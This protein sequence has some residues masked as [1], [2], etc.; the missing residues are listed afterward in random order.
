MTINL[1]HSFI[2]FQNLQIADGDPTAPPYD[3]LLV[4]DH[5]GG[6]SDAHSLSSINSSDDDQ[7]FQSLAQWGPRFGRLADMYSGGVEEDDDTET[8]PGKTEWV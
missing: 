4:F 3:S 5:E 1:I 2:H 8:L 6:G 7:D